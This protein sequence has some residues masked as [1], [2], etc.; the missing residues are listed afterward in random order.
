LKREEKRNDKEM[1]E[2]KGLVFSSLFSSLHFSSL[3]FLFS[4]LLFSALLCSSLL[5]YNPPRLDF[6]N[7]LLYNAPQSLHAVEVS[8]VLEA[9][10]AG[11]G[12]GETA[13][14]AA[15]TALCFFPFCLRVGAEGD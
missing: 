8:L 13:T 3:L 2:D 6:R 15:A 1:K 7:T 14:G 4:S 10:D 11:G 12:A 5:P 9:G